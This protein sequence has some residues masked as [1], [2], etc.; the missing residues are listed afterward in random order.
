VIRAIAL[1]LLL[2]VPGSER[3]QA[4]TTLHVFAAASLLDAFDAIAKDFERQNA[5]VKV[6]V[7]YAGS[8]TLAAQIEQGAEADVF[9]SADDRWMRYV[10]EKGFIEGDPKVFARNGLVFIVPKSNPGRGK[11]VA[12]AARAGVK[13]IVGSDQVP[14]GAY[15]R[16]A[17]SKLSSD[18][19]YGD[20]FGRRVLRNV[21]SHEDN[22]KSIVNKV[23]LG[24]ADAG[25]VYR[26][27]VAHGAARHLTTIELPSA[28]RVVA[29]Y[30]IAALRSRHGELANRFIAYVLS[31]AGQAALKK[32]KF[33][34]AS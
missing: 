6:R 19:A 25:F 12:D 13:V 32:E 30:P 34:P 23:A 15:T 24:E 31:P 18:P 17:L 22:V 10:A 7:Q 3:A 27:D 9:A 11:G 26:S 16:L 21:V 33:S 14:V 1:V 5:G 8:Q 2:L 20:D 29:H 4:K 28:A